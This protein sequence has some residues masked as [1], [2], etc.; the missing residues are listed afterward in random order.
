MLKGKGAYSSFKEYVN[1]ARLSAKL[2]KPTLEQPNIFT[3]EG[4]FF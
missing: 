3:K 4:K 1:S 2:K